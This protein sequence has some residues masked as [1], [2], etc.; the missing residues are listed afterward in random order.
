MKTNS[1]LTFPEDAHTIGSRRIK[2][3][4]EPS[5][6]FIGM[7]LRS[8]ISVGKGEE[9]EEN[10]FFMAE[11]VD[12]CAALVICPIYLGSRFSGHFDLGVKE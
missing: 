1:P 9:Y 12:H 8:T 7:V 2:Y 10:D 5:S 4:L 11:F 6:F 3:R